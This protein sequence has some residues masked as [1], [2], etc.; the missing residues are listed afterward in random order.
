MSTETELRQR[1]IPAA[2]VARE[3]IAAVAPGDPVLLAR[4]IY[5]PHPAVAERWLVFGDG[6]R[7]LWRVAD[8]WIA[9]SEVDELQGRLGGAHLLVEGSCDAMFATRARV[10]WA[11]QAVQPRVFAADLLRLAVVGDQI[12]LAGTTLTRDQL[13]GVEVSLSA[14]WSRHTVSLR[15]HDGHRREVASRV[16]VAA[17]LDPTYGQPELWADSAWAVELAGG[18]GALFGLDVR[19]PEALQG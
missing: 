12:E 18:L 1:C 13:A 8:A 19:L 2:Q 10:V 11:L 6:G 5:T 15:L 3:V 17:R 14:G 7:R 9:V 16:E 4:A